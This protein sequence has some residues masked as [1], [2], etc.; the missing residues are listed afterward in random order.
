M[1]SD[2]WEEFRS[3]ADERPVVGY[4]ERGTAPGLSRPW[5]AWYTEAAETFRL[6]PG[7]S[8]D[9]LDRATRARFRGGDARGIAGYVGFDAVSLWEPL[10]AR[11]PAGAPFPLGEFAVV[12]DLHVVRRL[13]H[14]RTPAAARGPQ[15]G[16]P[17][18]SET[19]PPARYRAAVGRVRAAIGR[20]EA[21]QVVVA[22]RRRFRRPDDLLA[23]AGLLRAR[24]R[25]AYFYYLRFGDREIVG[26]SPES[27]IELAGGR[28]AIHPIAGTLPRES[29]RGHRI[30]LRR[31]PKELAE[32]RMLVDLARNDLGKI[33]RP[34]TVRVAWRERQFRFARLEHLI[35]RVDGRLR[36]GTGPWTALAAAFPAGTVSGA[37]KIRATV[38]LRQQE[39]S[40]RGPYGGA[41]GL[42]RPHGAADWA[43]AIRTAYVRGADLYTAAGAGIVWGSTPGRE[44][45]EVRTKRSQIERTL[46][47]AREGRCGSS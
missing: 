35:S 5:A 6:R 23:R 42:L 31:D 10:L 44:E 19:L 1:R 26:A 33:C 41:V 24:E 28:A 2:P 36:P 22:S 13:P 47:A 3:C 20:G 45:R 43:L 11:R 32:H 38:L 21:F 27:V 37:P 40:W 30:P 9:R 18:H 15:P 8:P 16:L 29:D 4:L 39:R 25:F 7:D 34:G 17:A 12:R 46:V 14:R